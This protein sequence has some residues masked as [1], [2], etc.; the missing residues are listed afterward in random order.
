MSVPKL[1]M[2][3]KLSAGDVIAQELKYH[4]ACLVALYNRGRAF[5]NAQKQEK[6]EETLEGKN[7]CP[8]AFSEL[9]TYI[10]ETKNASEGSAPPVFRLGDLSCLYK[11]RLQQL[12]IKSPNT[13]ATR[14]KEQLL[15]HI[16]ELEAHHQ[17]RDVLLAFK[18]DVG[19]IIAQASKYGEAIYLAKAAGIIRNDML[20][21]KRPFNGTFHNGCLE[22]SFP[23]SLLQFV[24]IIEHGADISLPLHLE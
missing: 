23:E 19:K 8:M 24:C 11:E 18:T 10:T 3:A 22:D 21:H 15:F 12:G 2:M 5:L 7:A 6:A 13:H 1:S 4:S 20:K 9:V 17:G 14:L 16:L